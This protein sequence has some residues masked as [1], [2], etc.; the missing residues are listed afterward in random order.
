MTPEHSERGAAAVAVLSNMDPWEANLV[1]NLRLWCDG[2]RGQSQV[3]N[4]YR[5]ALPGEHATHACQAFETLVHTIVSSAHRPLVRHQVGCSCVGADEA[6]FVNLV[7]MAS[8]GHLNDAALVATLLMG[9][10]RA[11]HVAILAGQVGT[12]ARKISQQT[13][14]SLPQTAATVVRLH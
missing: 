6:V 4:E 7:R 2:S 11:E 9:P 1:L 10:A 14:Q 3:W 13:L 5:K 8:E 12:C